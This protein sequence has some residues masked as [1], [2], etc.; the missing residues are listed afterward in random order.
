MFYPVINGTRYGGQPS[1]Q[2]AADWLQLFASPTDT[3]G[4]TQEF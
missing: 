2:A 4:I 1:R 3:V